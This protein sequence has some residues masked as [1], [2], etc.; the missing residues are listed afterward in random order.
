MF[1]INRVLDA[2]WVGMIFGAIL[3]LYF[4]LSS[5]KEDG[6]P[7]R[8]TRWIRAL[9]ARYVMSPSAADRARDP[10]PE[11]APDPRYSPVKGNGETT[12]NGVAIGETSGNDPFPFPDLFTGLAR[13]VLDKKIGETDAITIA[14]KVKPGKGDKY[15]EARRRLHAAME[16]ESP[17]A[18]PLFRQDDGTTAPAAHPVSGQRR[19]I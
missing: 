7:S 19:P 1:G 14:I 8:L 11:N 16:R 9:N 12:G 13:L 3:T 18:D 4:Y 10:L 5:I 17:S 2:F 15:Q 6:G